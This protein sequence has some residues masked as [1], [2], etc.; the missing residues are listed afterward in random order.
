MP[1]Q[2][3]MDGFSLVELLIVIAVMGAMLAMS[4]PA[5]QSWANSHALRASADMIAGELQNLRARAMATGQQQT[6]HFNMNY[7]GHGDMH[8]HNGTFIGA[9][10]DLPN[11]VRYAHS[12][13]LALTVTR[14]GRFANSAYLVL[15]DRRNNR[16]TVSVQLSGLVLVR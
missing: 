5:Y 14:D 3:R 9:H 16:D 10:W 2:R 7:A 1:S 13:A 15:I 11:G 4:V 12:G 8:L 6:I